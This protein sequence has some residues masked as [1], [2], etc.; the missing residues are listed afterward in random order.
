[1][2]V[3]TNSP[4]E[5]QK[6]AE[7]L[8]KTLVGGDVVALYGELGAGKTI[9]VQGL[10]KG[11]NIKRKLTSPTFVF[12]RS[13]PFVQ[14]KKALTFYHLDL[15]RGQEKADFKNLGL[16]EIFSP[17]SIVVLEWADRIM[18]SLPKN[19]IDVVIETVNEKKRKIKIRRNK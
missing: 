10:A 7:K 8:A 4:K 15:Y 11:L 1:M 3:K 17:D 14:K 16:D 9:F 5:S 12:M 19:R 18:E 2:E 6:V 13:Y